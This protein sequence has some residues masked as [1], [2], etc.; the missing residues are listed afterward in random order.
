MT[1]PLGRFEFRVWGNQLGPFRDRLA[2][3]AA[4]SEPRESADT[5]ILSRTTDAANVKIRGGLLEIKLMFEQ[6][7]RLERWRPALKSEFPLDSRTIVEQVFPHLAVATPHIAQPS[8]ALGEFIHDLVRPHTDLAIIDVVKMRWRFASEKYT[9]EF[10]EV[11][12][13]GGATSETV[14]I[15]SEDP[16]AVLRA[17][18]RLGLNSHA[19][20]NY[21]RHLMLMTGTTPRA[22]APAN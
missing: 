20:I 14:A 2:A 18:A 19:N 21:V 16:A 3:T 15:E 13:A 4:P 6:V 8:Y 7:G 10:A 11:G 22:G 1:N 12:I 5:Y 9:A 17:I